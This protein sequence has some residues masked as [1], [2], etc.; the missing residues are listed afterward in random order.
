MIGKFVLMIT[1][2][3]ENWHQHALWTELFRWLEILR[4]LNTTKVMGLTTHSQMNDRSIM[5]SIMFKSCRVSCRPS[6]PTVRSALS[7]HK[8]V[9]T[10]NMYLNGNCQRMPHTLC[11]VANATWQAHGECMAGNN[12]RSFMLS[13]TFAHTKGPPPAH[14]A[15]S[16]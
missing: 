9:P 2:Y 3:D 13:N 1:L 5:I 11:D 7:F 4:F 16:L 8:V 6:S 14:G 12:T 10:T 15:T